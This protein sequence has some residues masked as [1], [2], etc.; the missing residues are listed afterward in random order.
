MDELKE[1]TVQ[2]EQ[3]EAEFMLEI[4]KL[5]EVS[6]DSQVSFVSFLDWCIQSSVVVG[7]KALVHNLLAL[8]K[9][10]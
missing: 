8:S 1:V 2:K 4:E 3:K 10:A 7:P 5:K 9:G 6:L